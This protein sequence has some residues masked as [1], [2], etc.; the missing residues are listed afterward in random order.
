MATLKGIRVLDLSRILAGPWCS[1]CLADLGAEIIKVE[2]PDSGDDTR[3]WGPPFLSETDGS[4]TDETAYFL[5]AN[6]GKKSITVNL[7]HPEGQKIIRELVRTSD[8]FIE[9]FKVGALARYGLDW[10]SL[11]AVHPGLIYCSITGFGQTGPARNRPGY[12]FMI[13]AEGGMMSLTGEPDDRPGGGPLK[14]GIAVSDL[15]TG[16]YAVQAILAALFEREKSGEGQYVDLAL[17]DSTVAILSMMAVSSLVSG[18]PPPRM[19]NAHPHV[20]P[21]RLYRCSDRPIVVTVGNDQQFARFAEAIKEPKLANDARFATNKLRIANRDQLDQMIEEKIQEQP[22]RHWETAFCK[23]E[24]P[25]APVNTIP[26]V[27]QHEQIQERGM[28]I[29]LPHGTGGSVPGP[30]NP[31][32]LSRTPVSYTSAAP[33]LGEHT[34]EVL[35]SVLGMSEMEI[36]RLRK[37]QAI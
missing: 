32:K 11:H 8:V 20:V 24:I 35:S 36:S 3:K 29:D 37:E 22:F 25:F 14:S 28:R 17:F 13:Q 26:E 1:Q 6:R 9:N 5:A 12:D 16:M 23:A 27:F 18:K 19:G 21:Y 7:A 31:I 2:R 15:F 33:V 4:E 30:A 34:E 10:K